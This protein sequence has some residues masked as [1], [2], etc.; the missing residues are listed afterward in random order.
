MTDSSVHVR[1]SLAEAVCKISSVVGQEN[2]ID[3]LVPIVTQLIKDS[4]TEV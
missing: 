2:S 3:H 4:H 1:A